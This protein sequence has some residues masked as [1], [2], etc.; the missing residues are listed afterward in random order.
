VCT[1][2]SI[3]TDGIEIKYHYCVISHVIYLWCFE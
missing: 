3:V 1:Y 2:N